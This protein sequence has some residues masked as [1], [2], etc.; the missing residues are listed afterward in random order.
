MHALEHYEHAGIAV[1]IFYDED[2]ASPRDA[3]NL[4]AMH[5][6][7]RGHDLGDLQLPAD[8]LPDIPCPACGDDDAE[9]AE[10]V[11]E[12]CEDWGQI[13]PTLGEWLASIH[14]IAAMPLFVYDHGMITMRGGRLVML[15]DDKVDPEDTNSIGR[16]VGDAQGWDTSFVGFMIVTE[17]QI[18]AICGDGAEYR[19]KEW[20]DSALRAELDEYDRYLRGE[21]YYYRVAEGTPF[22][23]SCSGF[24]GIEYAKE[25]AER[26]AELAA[27]Q[28]HDEQTEVA[29]WAARDVITVPAA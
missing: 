3:D 28:L 13:S 25:E 11:C 21:V 20:L 6:C 16:F 2:G 14:A 26:A 24:I 22:E 12:R 8:G 17:E 7:F 4:G 29:T 1:S 5:V 9:A 15:D 10:G 27:A 19:S 23:D 18:E